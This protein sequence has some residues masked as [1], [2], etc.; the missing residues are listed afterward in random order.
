MQLAGKVA[1]VTG[2]S[3]G[4]GAAVCRGYAREGAAVAVNHLPEPT[5]AALA[6]S[7]VDDIRRDGGQALAVPGDLSSPEDVT[8]MVARVQDGFGSVDILVNNAAAQERVPWTDITQE[9]WNHVLAVNL[10]GP[11]LLAQAVHAG[12]RVKGYGKIIMV[13]SVTAQLGMTSLLHY[14]TTKAGLIGFTRSLAREV[15]A[16]GIRVNAVMP[17]AIRTE[18]EVEDFPGQQ[19]ELREMLAERQCLPDRLVAEDLVGTF[20][21]LA[22]PASDAVTGQTILVDG[23]WVHR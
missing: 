4:I 11:L 5:M 16:E 6:E 7:V 1:L 23:G 14:V 9:A 20:V 12:M 10:T 21:Y 18:Q 8:A 2:A 3:R 22:A 15:G 17:G 13:S 19:D